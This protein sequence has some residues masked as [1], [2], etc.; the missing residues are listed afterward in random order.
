MNKDKSPVSFIWIFDTAPII[1]SVHP[2]EQWLIT[3]MNAIL[4]PSGYS[5]IISWNNTKHAYCIYVYEL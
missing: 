2:P 1:G 4:K 3:A 5:I